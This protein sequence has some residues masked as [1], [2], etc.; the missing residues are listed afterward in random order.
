M[1]TTKK[2][3]KTDVTDKKSNATK[4]NTTTKKKTTAKKK[5]IESTGVV[6]E[7]LNE[8][9]GK[10]VTETETPKPEKKKTTSKK[11]TTIKTDEN[12]LIDAETELNEILSQQITEENVRVADEIEKT[13]SEQE[14]LKKKWND[15]GL[16]ADLQV[17][18]QKTV[19]ELYNTDTTIETVEEKDNPKN[20]VY[21]PIK[22]KSENKEEPQE[23][24][25]TQNINDLRV[26]LE[27]KN[28][29]QRFTY[30]NSFMG[31]KYD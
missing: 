15:L 18:I 23:K 30:V 11:K 28:E 20:M 27:Q 29:P 26:N 14:E 19:S 4:K 9:I 10:V 6:D 17:N 24:E 2:T 8:N 7:F 5:E 13:I 21:P 22:G 3:V 12:K 31:V 25:Q 1:A 16:T